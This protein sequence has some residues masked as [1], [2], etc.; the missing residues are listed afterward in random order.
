MV[1][2]WCP[3]FSWCNESHSQLIWPPPTDNRVDAGQS[4]MWLPVHYSFSRNST[5][6]KVLKGRYK[7]VVPA[8]ISSR[9]AGDPCRSP[10]HANA[11]AEPSSPV[12]P[13]RQTQIRLHAVA[14][15]AQPDN[16]WPTYDPFVSPPPP[17]YS[18]FGALES[19]GWLHASVG[20]YPC[21]DGRPYSECGC[22]ADAILKE[23]G[24]LGHRHHPDCSTNTPVVLPTPN[25]FRSMPMPRW[26][27]GCV[28]PCQPRAR[29]G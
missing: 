24:R 17:P 5:F 1:G 21:D 3:V 22:V 18:N 29:R 8:P 16:A 25:G 14:R 2:S 13:R 28:V 11:T 20:T 26:C 15:N 6:D 9:F 23:T 4:N 19:G 27:T 10:S 12:L 7:N